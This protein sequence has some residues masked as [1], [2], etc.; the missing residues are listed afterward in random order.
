MASNTVAFVADVHVGNHSRMGGAYSAG[1]NDRC[2]GIV[3]V[4]S[5]SVEK[6][7]DA[8]CCAF[9]V[10]GDLFDESNPKP[11]IIAAT[12]TALEQTGHMVGQCWLLV[13]NHDQESYA[14]GDHAMAPMQGHARIVERPTCVRLRDSDLLLVP[15]QKGRASDWLPEAVAEA[16]TNAGDPAKRPRCLGIHLGI[17]GDDT[18]PFLRES[19]DAVPVSLLRELQRQHS[20]HAIIAGN[21]HRHRDYGNGIVQVGALVPNGFRDSGVEGYGSV[22]MWESGKRVFREEVPGPRYVVAHDVADIPKGV[23]DLRVRLS[24]E[25]EELAYSQELLSMMD[26][27]AYEV[28]PEKGLAVAATREAAQRASSSIDTDAAVA[29]Y[30]EAMPLADGVS[31]QDV[32]RKT[33]QFLREAKVDDE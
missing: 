27:A 32:L 10:L 15:F 20:L 30:V 7:M 9:V 25:P 31:R 12:Q 17:V 22:V 3:K 26:L 24:V 5:G 21:W 19:E 16:A 8:G 13:G 2:R 29:G 33:Q 1:L 28:I 14:P 4:L 23:K 18:V 6:A 11:Q